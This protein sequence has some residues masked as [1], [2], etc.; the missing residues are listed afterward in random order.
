MSWWKPLWN[1]KLR[2]RAASHAQ[3]TR[4][5]GV[6]EP[7]QSE[8]NGHKRNFR[9]HCVSYLHSWTSLLCLVAAQGAYIKQ[10]CKHL[11]NK[12][13][14][15]RGETRS[16]VWSPTTHLQIRMLGP[17]GRW[18][19][20]CHSLWDFLIFGHCPNSATARIMLLLGQCRMPKQK[21][22]IEFQ[23]CIFI[24]HRRKRGNIEK[25]PKLPKAWITFLDGK[26]SKQDFF[27]HPL[28]P[29]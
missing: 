12:L 3:G 9:K 20:A 4:C 23:I 1:E 29:N 2:H 6:P 21:K 11:R 18:V 27:S 13:R 10:K 24:Q 15:R 28:V 14:W 7:L 26:F 5:P 19:K 22:A 17:L 8:E 16:E 25:H